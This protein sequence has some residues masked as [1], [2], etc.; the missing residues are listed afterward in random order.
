VVMAALPLLAPGA[1]AWLGAFA[2]YP[3]LL[4][5]P[6]GLLVARLLGRVEQPA[7]TRRRE[8]GAERVEEAAPIA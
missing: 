8:A 6:L 5:L 3:A 1:P 7:P 4:A 2:R